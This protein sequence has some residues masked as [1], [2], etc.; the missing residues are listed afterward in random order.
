MARQ[1]AS[2]RVHRGTSYASTSE[3]AGQTGVQAVW[4]S[5]G[6]ALRDGR[7]ACAGPVGW[8]GSGAQYLLELLLDSPRYRE[9][10]RPLL[11][12][13]GELD[14]SRL[15]D[16]VK[17][18]APTARMGVPEPIMAEIEAL[19]PEWTP[20]QNDSEEGGTLTTGRQARRS[21]PQWKCPQTVGRESHSTRLRDDGPGSRLRSSP[22]GG[23]STGWP[24][25]SHSS[26]WERSSVS[27]GR[28]RATLPVRLPSWRTSSVT[29][30]SFFS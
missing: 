28:T 18:L 13:T 5:P 24:R 26:L 2:T 4:H 9:D 7:G 29:L 14:I 10:L 15:R 3:P 16:E 30:E 19:R 27:F 23:F 17:R 12:P 25:W 20:R 11:T 6:G 8:S 1:D 21:V 22:N